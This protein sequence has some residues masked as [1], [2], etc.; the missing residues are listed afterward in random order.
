MTFTEKIDLLFEIKF[1]R[2]SFMSLKSLILACSDD[3][4]EFCINM[5]LKL[6]CI[7]FM[8]VLTSHSKRCL[9]CSFVT[10]VL[11]IVADEPVDSELLFT[12]WT[13]FGLFRAILG[14]FGAFS[15]FFGL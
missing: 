5:S 13:F 11:L 8:V 10:S 3:K 12:V 2:K 7:L 6:S 1:K 9:F 15:G 14:Y 4:V